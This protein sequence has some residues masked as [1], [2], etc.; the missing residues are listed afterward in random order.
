MKK[1]LNLFAAILI[2]VATAPCLSLYYSQAGNAQPA[3]LTEEVTEVSGSSSSAASGSG[4]AYP[5]RSRPGRVAPVKNELNMGSPSAAELDAISRVKL[6][7]NFNPRKSIASSVKNLGS[8]AGPAALSR[9]Q[10][11]FLENKSLAQAIPASIFYSL[12]FPQWPVAFNVPAPLSSNNI[13][14]FDASAKPVLITTEEAMKQHFREHT[15]PIKNDQEARATLA[16]YLTLAEIFAQDGMYQFST[17]EDDMKILKED[18]GTTISGTSNV[19]PVGGNSGS[20]AAKLHIGP[21]GNLTSAQHSVNLQAGMR[22]ICQSTKLLDPDILVRRMAEQDILI[23]GSAAKP[24]LD[25]QR[26]KLSPALQKEIDRVWARIV[27]EGR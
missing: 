18:G 27:A 23:M 1:C 24:Y 10:L 19:R 22:P 6:P 25:E 3:Q 16:A 7:A 21:K 12:K 15:A 20:I 8:P 2:I 5:Q 9:A 11:Q 17:S 14:A 13:F 26:T 4:V